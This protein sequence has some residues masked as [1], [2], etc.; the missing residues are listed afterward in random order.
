M[1]KKQVKLTDIYQTIK[2]VDFCD[3]EIT[4]SASLAEQFYSTF[5]I[6]R[7]EVCSKADCFDEKTSII[8]KIKELQQKCDE[9]KRNIELCTAIIDEKQQEID[10]LKTLLD[11]SENHNSASS[12]IAKPPNLTAVAATP[13]S[14]KENIFSKFAEHFNEQQLVALRSIGITKTDDSKFISTAMKSLY[15]GRLEVLQT[16]S[17]TGRSKPGTRKDIFTPE[18]IT[19]IHD[20]I[21]E[22]IDFLVLDPKERVIRRGNVNKLIRDA[23]RNISI[24]IKSKEL[25]EQVARRLN[26]E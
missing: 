24:A 10:K 6:D 12:S 13:V 18:K 8:Q 11:S 14:S 16:K 2:N 19:I 9:R 22:R 3:K 26:F 1:S 25:S 15:D 23:Q 20:L 17:I 7:Q 5:L 21:A 4:S